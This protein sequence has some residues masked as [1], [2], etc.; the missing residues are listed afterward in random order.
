VHPFVK[1]ATVGSVALS[2]CGIAASTFAAVSASAATSSAP[3][4]VGGTSSLATAVGL[5]AGFRAGIYRFNKAG[6]LDGRK[7]DYLPSLNDGYSPATALANAQQLVQNKHVMVVAPIASAIDTTAVGTFL[8]ENKTPFIGWGTSAAFPTQPKWGFPINGYGTSPTSIGLTDYRQLLAATG[9]TKTPGKVKIAFIAENI[10]EGINANNSEAKGAAYVGMKVV[11]HEGP[12]PII[13]TTSYAPYAQTLIASGANAVFETLDSPDSVGLASALKAA[14]FK[15]TII[16]ALTYYPGQLASQ[17]SEAAA[18]NGVYV[19]NPFPL[20]Q[21]ETPAVKQEEKDLVSTGQPANLTAGVSE[22]YWSAIFL[23]Q[24]LKATLKSVGGNPD[25]VTGIT[26]EKVLANPKG[27]TYTDP[28]PGGIG[29]E[30]FPEAAKV[31][32]GCGT[33]VKTVGDNFKQIAPYQCLGVLDL[34]TN[35]QINPAT[36][37]PIS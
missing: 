31:P 20:N 12:I 18:L 23:E 29:T 4:L 32:T 21:N 16:N 10:A 1:L 30:T 34:T 26:I 37:K 11:Y 2:S 22:G 17:P 5:D 14:G 35:K 6:G 8:A 28:I 36:G 27:Y 33:L 24:A 15:G 9:N 13:G 7:I 19:V 3:I 25:K